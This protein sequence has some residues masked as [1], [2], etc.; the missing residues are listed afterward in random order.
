M[1]YPFVEPKTLTEKPAQP[2]SLEAFRDNG[3]PVDKSNG[4]PFKQWTIGDYTSRYTSGELT[5]VQ[6]ARAVLKAI[7][8]SEE[9]DY[10]LKLFIEKHDEMI[11]AQAKAS[12]K[13]YAQGKPLGVLDGVPVAIK[14]EMDIIGH[15]VFAGTS[16]IGDE[17]GIAT[18]D[19][20]PV[21]RLRSAG[22]IILGTTN[23][24]EIGAG[25]TGYNMHYG[26]VR[27]PYNPK[28][29]TGGSS[30]GSAAAVASGIVP[31][32][33]GVDG[34]G[35]VRIPAGICGV[36]GIKPTFQRVPPL[37]QDCPSVCHTGPIAGTVRDAAIGYAV[38]SGGDDGFL[39]SF[40]QPAVDL[41]SFDHTSSLEG[42][43][44]GYFSDYT[45]SSSPDIVA[46]V[47]KTL[48]ALK[49]RGAELIET[50]LNYLTAIHMAHSTT[51]SSEMAQSL[52]KYYSR[53]D[54]ISPEVQTVLTFSRNMLSMDYIAA[55][56]VRA[57]ALRQFQDEVLSKVDVFVTPTTGMT[58]PEIPLDA[59]EVGELNGKQLGD[60][61]RF[62]VYGNLIGVP[63]VAVPIGYDAKGL[64]ISIQFQGEHW[65]EDMI[66][67]LAHT[68]ERIYAEK[69]KQPQV[70]FSILDDAAKQP[71]D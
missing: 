54:E 57:F 70:Y 44:I 2:L 68:T 7:K 6:V 46:A 66:L 37:F 32:A 42:V 45:N 20:P 27:N 55:Q 69:Q 59:F 16:F 63:G 36:V 21:A 49:A 53:F 33:V 3:A 39:P 62:S 35:S 41:H 26:T 47:E 56:R 61:F 28:H 18:T 14:D 22:A 31:L 29:Y 38:M 34:G 25:V 17:T 4:A 11:M 15:K 67:R 1:F 48:D 12:A 50:K 60:I 30:S 23:M 58:G 5:P 9:G 19:S 13:R 10:P 52:D 51:I 71:R 40:H 24:H 65:N 8:E 43:K 64:P